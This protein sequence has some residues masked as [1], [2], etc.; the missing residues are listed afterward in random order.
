V[1]LF[2]ANFE[3]WA[4]GRGEYTRKH[5]AW[6]GGLSGLVL[7]SALNAA[8]NAR[9]R[10]K[11]A[12]DAAETWRYIDSMLI[13]V[14]TS[15]IALQGCGWHDLWYSDLRTLDYT[16]EGLILQMSGSPPCRLKLKSPDYWYVM[17]RKFAF[18]EIYDVPVG[19]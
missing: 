12:R 14:T 10:S 1:G 9:R 17:V 8:G 7:G 6:A 5:V 4:E 18:N 15:R 11:A 2:Q 19:Q 16:W 13:Y 3:Q